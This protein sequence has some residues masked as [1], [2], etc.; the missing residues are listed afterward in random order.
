MFG[1][2]VD[3]P[4]VGLTAPPADP[5]TA[6]QPRRLRPVPPGL[7]P[8]LIPLLIVFA[9]VVTAAPVG[10]AIGLL[11]A[12]FALIAFLLVRTNRATG[13]DYVAQRQNDPY[14]RVKGWFGRYR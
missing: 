2:P 1:N 4:P 8:F 3:A 5:R 12:V 7:V 13:Y 9:I 11:L 10:I 14:H 6:P